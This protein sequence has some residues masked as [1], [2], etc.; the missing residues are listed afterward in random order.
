MIQATCRNDKKLL[1]YE[2]NLPLDMAIDPE[3]TKESFVENES[4]GRLYVS[5]KKHKENW[6][7]ERLVPAE[8]SKPRNMQVWWDKQEKHD[9]E[10]EEKMENNKKES[11]YIGAEMP[12]F[13]DD[14]EEEGFEDSGKTKK[15]KK[16]GKN[17]KE[18]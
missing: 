6:K 15:K 9:K 12:D 11:T 16:K 4:V 8:A 2:L 18:S 17:K 10:L 3:D 14:E 1:K 13:E 5:L 7:W